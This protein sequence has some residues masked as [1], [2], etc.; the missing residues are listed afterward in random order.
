ILHNILKFVTILILCCIMKNILIPTDFSE[1]SWN[2][3]EYALQ[4]YKKDRCNI[5]LL[6]VV[7]TMEYLGDDLSLIPAINSLEDTMIKDAK[8]QLQTLEKRIGRLSF[9][10]KHNFIPMAVYGL[11][12]DTLRSEVNDKEIDM[13]VMGTKGASGLKKV[14]LGSNA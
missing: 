14:V 8:A 1:N 3:I 11:F 10:T 9:N 4:L 5:Y 7:S 2:A 13:I 6:H 12:L